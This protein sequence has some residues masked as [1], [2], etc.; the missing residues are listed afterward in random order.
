MTNELDTTPPPVLLQDPPPR[1]LLKSFHRRRIQVWEGMVSV[2]SVRGWVKNRRTELHVQTFRTE[3]GREPD[4]EELYRLVL[5]DE[6]QRIK[7]LADNIYQNGVRVPIILSADGRL[8]DGNRRYFAVKFL[9]E[10]LKPSERPEFRAVPAW[11]LASSTEAEDEFNVITERNLVDDQKI[12]WPYYV[13][14]LQVYEDHVDEGMTIK[15]IAE[16]YDKQ[17]S[18]IRQM[19]AAV[20]LAQEFTA[21]H[22]D[23]GNG[24]EANR[25][26]YE[27]L[28]WF[29]Q[30]R[31]SHGKLL[32]ADADFKESVFEMV[33]EE[34]PK[35]K[36][37]R[38]FLKLSE[39][40]QS[41]KAW[42]KLTST[43]GP[44]GLEQALRV[45]AAE[46][47]DAERDPIGKLE[48]AVTVLEDIASAPELW[49]ADPEILEKFH[50]LSSQVPV[51]PSDPQWKF[52]RMR[53]WLDEMTVEQV[54]ELGDGALEGLAQA[55]ER[56]QAMAEAW[57][58]RHGH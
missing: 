49:N 1:S 17:T 28:I 6:L 55:Q 34:P 51:G 37:A 21:Y 27:N 30:L 45:V 11:V 24:T 48:R 42:A 39:I 12:Q 9:L 47:L 14:A 54:A 7:A 36:Q 10:S 15:E 56:V 33:L 3:F 26:V 35:F 20:E 16:K 25:V 32:D 53:E 46:R 44:A 19:I 50:R 41:P 38:D 8:L 40:R 4:D 13:Q 29:D 23:N 43:P 58:Q 22:D 2:E 5:D 31:R 18:R 57:A 52:E